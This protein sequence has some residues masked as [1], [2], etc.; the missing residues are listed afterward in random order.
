MFGRCI[1]IGI[2]A[3]NGADR[4]RSGV[5]CYALESHLIAALPAL[6]DSHPAFRPKTNGFTGTKRDAGIEKVGVT[7]PAVPNES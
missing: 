7:V 3:G 5:K 2:H 1:E 6:H 4:D